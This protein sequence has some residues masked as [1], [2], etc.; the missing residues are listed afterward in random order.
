MNIAQ[1]LKSLIPNCEFS[2]EDNDYEKI[3]WFECNEDPQPS[4]KDIE[5][6][7]DRL[8]AE[9]ERTEYQRQRKLE[10]PSI[11][12]QL[13]ALFHAGAFPPEIAEKIQSVKDKYPK[14]PTE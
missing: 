2:V 11:G 13:D 8:K 1:A 14:P 3:T 6:E 5:A 4:K 10:Y 12:D 7:I 9:H